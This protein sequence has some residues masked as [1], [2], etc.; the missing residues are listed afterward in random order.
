L[1]DYVSEADEQPAKTT[2]FA[3]VNEADVRKTAVRRFSK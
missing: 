2:L 3:G 1:A